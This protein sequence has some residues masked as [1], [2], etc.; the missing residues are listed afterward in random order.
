MSKDYKNITR[1]CL[2]NNIS[3]IRMRAAND[4][5]ASTIGFAVE[6]L[7]VLRRMI[8]GEV[9]TFEDSGLSKH[10]WHALMLRLGYHAPSLSAC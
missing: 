2:E 10:D 1:L 6:E 3:P 5:P 9:V 7:A 4:N 8:R